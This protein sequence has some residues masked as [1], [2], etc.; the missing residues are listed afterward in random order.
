MKILARSGCSS[1]QPTSWHLPTSSEGVDMFVIY[2]Q[3]AEGLRQVRWTGPRRNV[4]EMKLAEI[5]KVVQSHATPEEPSWVWL[6]ELPDDADPRDMGRIAAVGERGAVGG[7]F[8]PGR[9][10]SPRGG[11]PGAARGTR[12]RGQGG[13][14]SY[15]ADPF[16]RARFGLGRAIAKRAVCF[17]PLPL[18]WR[19]TTS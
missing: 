11:R 17:E 14:R 5:D 10:S 3:R 16:Q 12:P 19:L 8:R 6:A 2:A 18:H 4:A 13:T 15:P 9:G 7:R 1:H